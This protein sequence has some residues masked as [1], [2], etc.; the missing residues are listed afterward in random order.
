MPTEI[1]RRTFLL[2]C[3]GMVLA[4]PLS[5]IARA[6]AVVNPNC[7]APECDSLPEARNSVLN[8]TV[9]AAT[10]PL[11]RFFPPDRFPSIILKQGEFPDKVGGIT[12]SD[13]VSIFVPKNLPTED[14]PKEMQQ[15]IS[16]TARI[17]VHETM[18]SLNNVYAKRLASRT[19]QLIESLGKTC[20]VYDSDI[21]F[22]ERFG[23]SNPS[24]EYIG[25]PEENRSELLASAIS[26]VT[27][28][29]A[30]LLVALNHKPEFGHGSLTPEQIA[31][32]LYIATIT[33][34]TIASIVETTGVAFPYEEYGIDRNT[35]VQ[36][37]MGA[38]T[39]LK[40]SSPDQKVSLL[41]VMKLVQQ[42]D[43]GHH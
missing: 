29:T 26:M 34:S 32:K 14:H 25:H 5:S 27:C 37:L 11:R 15:I 38:F 21:I 30:E 17:G 33:A 23:N 31:H 10:E 13:H 24:L 1:D 4:P 43:T 41:H 35:F 3:L 28:D 39:P 6:D 20:E 22:S 2:G 40:K 18:H 16:A 9:I 42:K 7:G 19:Q 8:D 12:Y 36:A